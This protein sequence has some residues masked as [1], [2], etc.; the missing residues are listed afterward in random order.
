MPG[1]KIRWY[2]TARKQFG[3]IIDYVAADSVQNADHLQDRLKK[4]LDKIAEYPEMCP[5]DKY[6][7]HND[8]SFRA[9]TLFHYRVSYRF[10]GT[11]IRV[12]RIR[13]TSMKPKYF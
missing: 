12:L 7:I 6:K 1:N 3:A 11:E 9:F 5:K 10:Y 13:H 4:K 8:G 2:L